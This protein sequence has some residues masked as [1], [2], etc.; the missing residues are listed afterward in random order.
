MADNYATLSTTDLKGDNVVTNIDHNETNSIETK[1]H[2]TGDDAAVD[3]HKELEGSCLRPGD[4]NIDGIGTKSDSTGDYAAVDG[5]K[6]LDE[7]GRSHPAGDGDIGCIETKSD[8][9]G[10][11]AAVDGYKEIDEG[12]CLHPGDAN[13]GGSFVRAGESHQTDIDNEEMSTSHSKGRTADAPKKNVNEGNKS[14]STP[15][16]RRV[17]KRLQNFRKKVTERCKGVIKSGRKGWESVGKGLRSFRGSIYGAEYI[18][19]FI[20]NAILGLQTLLAAGLTSQAVMEMWGFPAVACFTTKDPPEA[21]VA[22]SALC[23]NRSKGMAYAAVGVSLAVLVGTCI[24]AIT[25]YR[26]KFKP[27]TEESLQAAVKRLQDQLQRDDAEMHQEE[28]RDPDDPAFDI[29]Q[30]IRDIQADISVLRKP[31]TRYH[32][33]CIISFGCA[34]EVVVVLT[35]A[36]VGW[37]EKFTC[38]LDPLRY[39]CYTSTQFGYSV[40]SALII[41]CMSF[42]FCGVLLCWSTS[43]IVAAHSRHS[44]MI[45]DRHHRF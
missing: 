26:D 33:M 14:S 40:A 25:Q 21:V 45:T 18:H 13:T 15:S 34:L 24:Y 39:T 44:D 42:F 31:V 19:Y 8:S 37:R 4:R 43:W 17:P 23:G 5:Y 27:E 30:E 28:E 10:D 9:T 41:T 7:G 3:G 6:E 11:Y 32:L 16:L 2:L 36:L 1:T 22:V 12:S 20:V 38:H 35:Y 29:E